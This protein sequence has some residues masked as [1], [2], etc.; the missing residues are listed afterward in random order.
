MIRNSITFNLFLSVSF[1][2]YNPVSYCVSEL[3]GEIVQ[4]AEI[5]LTQ[6]G[7]AIVEDAS[8]LGGL[9]GI[10]PDESNRQ[11]RLAPIGVNELMENL[12]KVPSS[13][14]GLKRAVIRH[15]STRSCVK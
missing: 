12:E 2:F 13:A 11:K 6:V 15:C 5:I 8:C 3:P 9:E 10:T 7:P 4:A 14:S 1:V